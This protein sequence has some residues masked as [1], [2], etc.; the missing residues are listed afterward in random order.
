M[1]ET[2]AN[3]THMRVLSDSFQMNTNMTG[4]RWFSKSLC[5]C[6]L[7]ES[8]LSTGRVKVLLLVCVD[9]KH[10]TADVR[11]RFTKHV[12]LNLATHESLGE[13]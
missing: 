9:R 12:R 5:T 13:S 1:V 10:W 8:S 7:D 2:M 4:F 6:A 3:G 11:K